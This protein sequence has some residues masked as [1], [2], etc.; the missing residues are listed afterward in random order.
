MAIGER[1]RMQ[2]MLTT[3]IN[4][5]HRSA[6]SHAKPALARAPANTIIEAIILNTVMT[7]GILA[8]VWWGV[9]ASK[10]GDLKEVAQA[11]RDFLEKNRGKK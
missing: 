3:T 1:I 4:A 9:V 6:E 10:N 7:F 5:W 11:F 2:G 8:G